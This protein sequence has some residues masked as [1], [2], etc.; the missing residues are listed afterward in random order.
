MR[1]RGRRQSSNVED[2]RGQ[3]GFRAGFPGGGGLRIPMGGGRGGGGI[4]I[5]GIL[6]LLGLMLFLGIDPSVLLQG[7]G[8]G[9]APQ[10]Q[11]P[12]TA[13]DDDLKQFVSVV[14]AD[15]EDVWNK[16][17]SDNG[18]S[19]RDPTLVLYSGRVSSACGLGMA[20]MGPFYCPGDQKVYLDLSFFRE[21]KQRFGAPGDFAQA[22]VVA[23]EV[24]HHVQKQLGIADQ[25]AAAQRGASKSQ[26]N[27]LQVRMEL[28]ADCFAGIWA[29]R[30]DRMS[31][32][33]QPGDIDEA[34]QAASAIGDDR[35][36]RQSQGYVVPDSFT[37]GSSAMRVRWFKRGYES[38]RFSDCDT[39]QAK[40]L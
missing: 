26:S 14:L 39:F 20:A 32:I 4:G 29:N 21:L 40:Q 12:R 24:G 15:T 7:S 31:D 16:I 11:A 25:V 27:A 22:Y 3:G 5:V 37:H 36:Q 34:L 8:E 35:L 10:T 2:R 19:Y 6:I 30:A 28:Q 13:E 23:H 38:G 9:P 1:W 18:R 33:L 17:F